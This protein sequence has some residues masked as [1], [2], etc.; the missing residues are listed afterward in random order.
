MKQG[1]ECVRYLCQNVFLHAVLLE[2]PLGEVVICKKKENF[3][4]LRF[5]AGDRGVHTSSALSLT[6]MLMS[7][8]SSPS[9]APIASLTL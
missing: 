6:L 9:E 5:V 2:Q 3:L 7:F 8:L 4:I 1:G